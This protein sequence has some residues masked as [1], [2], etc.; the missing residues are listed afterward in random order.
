MAFKKTRGITLKKLIQSKSKIW[1][2]EVKLF[3]EF[4]SLLN[5]VHLSFYGH[6]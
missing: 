3:I 5:K 1:Q 4:F 2:F 6:I